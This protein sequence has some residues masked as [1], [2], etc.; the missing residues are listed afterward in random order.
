[1]SPQASTTHCTLARARGAFAALTLALTVATLAPAMFVSTAHAAAGVSIGAPA[2]ASTIT[3]AP[4]DVSFALAESGTDAFCR[5]DGGDWQPCYEPAWRVPRLANGAHT[6][7][8]LNRDGAG[9]TAEASV[10]FTL[11]DTTPPDATILSPT[12][13]ST[14]SDSGTIDAIGFDVVGA[15]DRA[16]CGYDDLPGVECASMP[17]YGAS[18]LGNGTHTARLVAVDGAG[19]VASVS[20]SFTVLDTTPPSI[21][22]ASPTDGATVTDQP[23]FNLATDDATARF[24]AQ[25]DNGPADKLNGVATTFSWRPRAMAS[26]SHAVLFRAVDAAGNETALLRTVTVAD[27]TPP[28]LSGLTP[29]EGATIDGDRVVVSY[30]TDDPGASAS[31][32]IGA[33]VSFDCYPGASFTIADVPPG[34]TQLSVTATDQSGNATVATTNFTVSDTGEGAL[35]INSPANGATYAAEPRL[36]LSAPGGIDYA[37]CRFGAGAAWF[38]CVEGGRIAGLA[39]GS[40]TLDVRVLTLTGDLLTATTNFTVTDTTSPGLNVLYPIAGATITRLDGFTPWIEVDDSFADGGPS[41]STSIRCKLDS[42]SFAS[43]NGLLAPGATIASGAHQLTVLAADWAGNRATTTVSFGI[44]DTS[45]PVVKIVSP[46]DGATIARGRPVVDFWSDEDDASFECSMDADVSEPCSPDSSWLP[47][48]QAGGAI[49]PGAHTLTVTATDG[50]GNASSDSVAIT[51]TDADA[52]VLTIVA[53]AGASTVSDRLTVRWTADEPI[54]RVRCRVDVGAWTSEP[55]QCQ[56]GL[57]MDSNHGSFAPRQVANGARALTIEAFDAA[58]NGGSASVFVT[59]A[60]STPPTVQ[61]LG[62][63]YPSDVPVASDAPDGVSFLSDDDQATFS[64]KLDGSAFTACGESG[65]GSWSFSPP[66]SG[67]HTLVVRATDPAGLTADAT[68]NFTVADLTPPVVGFA[69]NGAALFDGAIV[70][71]SFTALVSLEGATSAQCSIDGA[72][73][74]DCFGGSFPVSGLAIGAHT[75]SVTASDASGNQTTKSVTVTAEAAPPPPTDGPA[76]TPDAPPTPPPLAPSAPTAKFGRIRPKFTAAK[77]TIPVKVALTLPGGASPAACAGRATL[78]ASVG[79]KRLKRASA[80]L[81]LERGNCA[82]TITL[83]LARKAVAGKKLKLSLAFAGTGTL[84][85][86]TASKAVKVRR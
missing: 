23:T 76:P 72:A 43:C 34:A 37:R 11:A 60:D 78:T 40:V 64:C 57:G 74:T 18:R 5:V 56:V 29:A 33:A 10:S 31:C 27:T 39:N 4:F 14:E 73:A 61:I 17:L 51:V 35:T 38:D 67:P 50:A 59:V 86:F 7:Q 15:Y 44:G 21:S 42:G 85:A 84:G 49:E 63:L 55:T 9:T 46:D 19:N 41:T 25:I 48:L 68:I 30:N 82:I 1:M 53:P 70:P 36:A 62:L 32:R 75:L 77:V 81:R 83:R 24:Y 3:E 58:G 52:P 12:N 66:A 69:Y 47:R 2:A 13:G 22:V 16:V 26:G 71:Q 20:T 6:V 45:A 65:V 8:I 28:A 80:A 54:A 79:R